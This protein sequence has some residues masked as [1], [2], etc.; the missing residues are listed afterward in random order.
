MPTCDIPQEYQICPVPYFHSACFK[1]CNS[2]TAR[3]KRSAAFQNLTFN[4]NGMQYGL[5]N[6]IHEAGNSCTG[7]CGDAVGTVYT[8]W[9][10][11]TCNNGSSEL[12]YEGIVG[13][14]WFEHTGA[15]V[16]P[17]CLPTQPLWNRFNDGLSNHAFMYGA[18]YEGDS[19][20]IFSL[21]NSRKL[22]NENIPCA[23]CRTKSRNSIVMVPAR[24]VCYPGWTL[25]YQGYLMAGGYGHKASS[26]Y[27]CVDEAPEV[28]ESGFR[29]EDGKL[30]YT[31]E[32]KCGSLPCPEYIDG[33]E[34]TCA[35][36]YIQDGEERHV[37][38]D[39][40]SIV[41]GSWYEHTG[42]AVNPLCLPTQPLWNRFVEGSTNHAV[43]HGAE[44]EGFPAGIFSMQNSKSRTL[45]NENI[46]CAVCRTK[47]R[48]SIVMVPARNVCYP[49]WTLEYQGYLMAGYLGHK[50]SSMYVC[51]DEAPEVTE[52]GFRD[53]NGKL[54]HTVEA[55]CGSLPCPEY[56]DGRELT[57]AKLFKFS[58]NL[59][60][61]I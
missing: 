32:A 26:M 14:S 8:R 54:F 43:M 52:S 9:G 37:T 16:N 33:R 41:G 47:S 53:E 1:E 28:T 38:M 56:I 22:Y 50:A 20:S 5:N 18:E 40:Q 59:R 7:N 27:V 46:P 12:I 15:A 31:V 13:G 17:L 58:L 39:R 44:Y 23:V 34:L 21:Q 42:A 29:D 3:A 11:K 36:L 49:G 19:N 55:K 48:N 2:G 57:C 24:N 10:R 25:E 60:N 6:D 45:L 61:K 35:E 4:Q 30:F 51:V